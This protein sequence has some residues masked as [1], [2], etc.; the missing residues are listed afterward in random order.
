MPPRFDPN[1]HFPIYI[2]G[3]TV[4]V[5]NVVY[6]NRVIPIEVYNLLGL[7]QEQAHGAA[8]L[9]PTKVKLPVFSGQDTDN[10]DSWLATVESQM[11]LNDVPLNLMV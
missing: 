6:P 10:L 7:N 9:V 2:P 1:E 3:E 5:G 11:Q 4:R 8:N